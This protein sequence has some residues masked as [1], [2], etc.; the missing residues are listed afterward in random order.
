MTHRRILALSLA[1]IAAMAT[2]ALWVGLRLPGDAA[3]PIHWSMAGAPDAFGSKWTSLF[4]PTGI[5]AA[6]TLGFALLPAVEPMRVNLKRS[7]GLLRTVWASAMAVVLMLHLMVIDAALRWGIVDTRWLL[8]VA[9]LLLVLLGNQLGKSRPTFLLGIRTP[10]TL[11]D[12]D[13]WIATHR[14]GGKLMV[15]AGLIWIPFV[16]SG[17]TLDPRLILIVAGLVFGAPV[18]YS[19]LV[20]RRTRLDPAA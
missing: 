9:G 7:A 18:L 8:T 2:S 10:W 19:Y 4:V 12:R 5:A 20:W 15:I 17:L 13:V 1:L 11:A 6:M 16:W 3:L 14:F